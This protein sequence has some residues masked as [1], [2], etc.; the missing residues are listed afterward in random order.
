MVEASGHSPARTFGELLDR[1]GDSNADIPTLHRLL[2]AVL[3]VGSGLDLDLTLQRIITSATT[4]LDCRYGALGVAAPGGGLS[5]FVYEGI[6]GSQRAT[7]GH[8]PEGHGVLGVLMNHPQTLRVA[9]LGDHPESVGFP[10][11]H[12]PMESFL[13]APIMMRG[14]VFGSIYLTEKR[15]QA[16]FTQ[17]DE[18]ILEAL[19]IAAG[20]AVE[21]ARLFEQSRTRERWL[22][23]TSAI[24]SRLLA[25]DSLED[26]LQLLA[27]RVRDLTG[28]DDVIVVICENGYAQVHAAASARTTSRGVRI[29]ATTY[30][31]D[32]VRS[33]RKLQ[34]LTTLGALTE[35]V[36]SAGSAVV[37][38]M[39]VAS[40]VVG[41]VIVASNSTNTHWDHDELTR[42]ESMAELGSVAIEFDEKQ[43]A[44]RL[45]SVLADR[46]RIARDLHDNVIQRLFASGM[47]LQSTLPDE[48]LPESARAIV[49]RS[50]EQLDKTVRE[51]R[52]TIFDLQT[53]TATD[54][55]SLRRRLL[56]VI[57][58]A[59]AQSAVSPS[60][61]FSGAIDTLVNPG[62]HQHAEAVLREGLSN[63]LR[64][65]HARHITIAVT[66]DVEFA[67]TIEDDGV[68]LP[69][70][71]HKS[72]LHNLE[73][74]AE[75][76]G[77]TCTIVNH[78]PSGARLLWRVP[79]GRTN[80][81]R[82]KSG[83]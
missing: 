50:L 4:V 40:G 16:E 20:I 43:K 71:F 59:T 78:D 60:V 10:A 18:V 1:L 25:G 28:V 32:V 35:L 46:D 42:I 53:P 74:R 49:K 54:S 39:C 68:G 27:S 3:V 31:F 30:P 64:H 29:P 63:V 48:T 2:E 57:G 76:C 38:P 8:F 13:G 67:I 55:S 51:I 23:A 61:Q 17:E 44:Q 37:A 70:D 66:A 81:N 33:T 15:G 56:D 65:A 83:R 36:P 80:S 82:P 73:R 79:L 11:N 22:T 77:G 34:V 26:G 41:A 12:P 75:H 72:G 7:M 47:S 45:L 19:A 21:N 6:S 5:E 24:R 62:I 69:S 9:H 52:T 58:D 14:K